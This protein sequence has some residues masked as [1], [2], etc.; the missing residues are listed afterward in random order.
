VRRRR[1]DTLPAATSSSHDALR[2]LFGRGS[3]YTLVI[4][5]QLSAALLVVPIVT[6]LL[7]ASGYGEIATA[8]VVSSIVSIFGA[9]GL[10]EAAARTFFRADGGIDD[11]HRLIVATIGI[12]LA[13]GLIVDLTGPAWVHV[14]G[15]DY[16]GVVRLAVW[17]GAAQAVTLATQ[18]L[19]RAADRVWGFLI[20]A[21]MASV[22][23]QGL[24]LLLVVLDGSPLSYMAGFVAGTVAA[25]AL[26][27]LTTGSLWHGLPRPSNVRAGLALGMPLIPHSMALYMLVAIDRVAIASVLG[28]AAAGRYQVAYAV[29][30]IGVSLITALN[31]AWIPLLLGADEDKRDEMLAE[32]SKTVH[33]F[34]GIV[35]GALALAAPLGLVFAAP[36]SYHRADLVPVA[37]TVA[38]SILPYATMS[39]CFNALFVAGRTR[40]MAV[41]APVA[42]A[43]NLV[44]N[45]LLLPVIGLVGASIA[46]VIGYSALAGI[47]AVASRRETE[48]PEVLSAALATWVWTAPV[49][50]AGA[51]L[52]PTTV[53]VGLRILLAVGLGLALLRLATVV[54][55]GPRVTAMAATA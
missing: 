14:L 53:G 24:G 37:A 8:L 4:A 13:V 32:T 26:G 45:L 17:G 31:Q 20:V 9:A 42:A 43:L 18:S 21:G 29:G 55:R 28:L 36:P 10:P 44:L 23:A 35:A 22:G 47:I 30:G 54:R 50:A 2:R 25:A 41:A 27:V 49:V 6:R 5:I 11:A 46:T 40:I 15:L 3:I 7:S 39:T 48:L 19:L 34:A 12:A 38:F 33:R 52:P 51:L 1:L 16:S